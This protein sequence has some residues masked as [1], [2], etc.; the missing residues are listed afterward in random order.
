MHRKAYAFT[1]FLLFPFC[2]CA[3]ETLL[4]T[5]RI[6]D[7]ISKSP[8]PYAAISVA[9]ST[10]GTVTNNDGEFQLTV[11]VKFSSDTLLVSYLG[12]ELYKGRIHEL[13]GSPKE[14]SLQPRS[15]LLSEVEIIGLTAEEV[16]R[17]VVAAIPANYGEDSLI[18]TA[19]IRSRKTVNNKLAE[20][21]EAI[22]ENMKT[23][24]YLYKAGAY[25]RK[26]ESSNIP[27]LLK[28]RVVSDTAIVNSMGEAGREAGCLGC[29]FVYDIA[30]F[31]HT[32]ILDEKLFRYYDFR[33][34]EV[35]NPAGGKIY[36]IFYSQKAGVKE[37]LWKGELFIESSSF[38][39]VK[40]TQKPSFNAWETYEKT[41]Y[42]RSY[43]I[44]N[45]P[46]WI[47]DMPLIDRT[48]TYAKHGE[49]WYLSTIRDEEWI[50]FNQP[51]SG[52][53][54]RFGYKNEVVVTDATRDAGKI[55]NFRGDKSTGSG[56]RWDQIA[57]APDPDFWAGFNY[58]PVEEKLKNDITEIGRK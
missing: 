33:M 16:I 23:G 1:F 4:L 30:E 2:L 25:S 29:N 26:H 57:G 6:N 13:A 51:A 54:L 38:A 11:P 56:Q 14:I 39:L 28:G 24:Y 32:T 50:T 21:T 27:L 48:V 37:K 45:Q 44:R 22:V 15:L 19:F 42:Q 40:M 31:Y 34:E 9:N 49:M 43:Y 7:A 55:R 10:L 12:Y 47:A 46:G 36:H 58:L 20:F 53:R 17:R 3:Q 5:G 35:I 52:Q 41:K 18:L 8:L